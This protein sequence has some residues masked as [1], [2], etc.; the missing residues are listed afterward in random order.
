MGNIGQVDMDYIA[1]LGIGGRHPAEA[2]GP[3]ANLEEL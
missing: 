3:M 1:V 2:V